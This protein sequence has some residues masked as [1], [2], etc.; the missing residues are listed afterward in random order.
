MTPEPPI[1]VDA[2]KKA[3]RESYSRESYSRVAQEYDQATANGDV[4]GASA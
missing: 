3:E 1:D 2:L 4:S